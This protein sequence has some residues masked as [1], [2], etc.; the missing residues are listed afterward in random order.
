MKLFNLYFFLLI[1][2][3]LIITNFFYFD[4]NKI[5]R[6]IQDYK[7]ST[8][9]T[10]IAFEKLEY[11]YNNIK[12]TTYV[13]D[14]LYK[15]ID[16]IIKN[17]IFYP[18]FCDITI[19]F[20]SILSLDSYDINNK[21]KLE[22]NIN[23]IISGWG[24]QLSNEN[25]NKKA[26]NI[27]FKKYENN[28]F[29][30]QEFL[31]EKSLEIFL[32]IKPQK[33]FFKD[34]FFITTGLRLPYSHFQYKLTDVNHDKLLQYFFDILIPKNFNKNI[35]YLDYFIDFHYSINIEIFKISIS[36]RIKF[37]NNNTIFSFVNFRT[38]FFLV[39]SK[40]TYNDSLIK[41]LII[42]K[43]NYQENKKEIIQDV[44]I[45]NDNL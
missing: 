15:V 10:K 37:S 9:F 43:I 14:V 1:N 38:N 30:S 29:F 13:Y 17:V 11:N 22:E 26:Y 33:I 16:N 31:F 18:I 40:K 12:N 25:L 35:F 19:G 2:N 42:E 4:I 36:Y 39:N 32:I 8:F 28:S 34:K 23:F 20:F 27:N 6:E 7:N 3:C 44:F 5:K 24:I 41:D 21:K 45:T